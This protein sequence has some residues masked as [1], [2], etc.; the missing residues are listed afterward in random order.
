MWVRYLGFVILFGLPGALHA[1]PCGAPGLDGGYFVPEQ[2]TYSHEIEITYACDSGR[3]PAV[4]GWWA[5]STCQNGVWSP[6]PQCIG[7]EDCLPP[8]I[9]NAKF[10]KKQSGW[11]NP[12]NTIRVTCDNEYE[13][14]N[15]DATAVCLNGTWTSVPVCEIRNNTC[16]EPPQIPHAVIIGQKYQ[17]IFAAD[18]EVRYE[19][20]DGYSVEGAESQKNIF[21]ISGSWSE[22]PKCRR[23]TRQ[24]T[25]HGG[26]VEV[27]TSAGSGTQ[28]VGGGSGSSAGGTAGGHS[29]STESGTQPGGGG[30]GSGDVVRGGPT[31]TGSSTTSV[32]N[33][34]N[35]K[36]AFIPVN[37]CGVSPVIP[38]GVVVQTER[39]YLKYQ[40]NSYYTRVGPEIVVCTNDGRW[41]E[42]PFCQEAFCV[43]DLAQYS[44]IQIRQTGKEYIKEGETKKVYCSSYEYVIFTCTQGRLTYTQCKYIPSFYSLSQCFSFSF[45]SSAVYELLSQGS[46]LI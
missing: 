8:E 21:C 22:G 11:Y 10:N 1:Q 28:T 34:R 40:C 44:G 42:L 2:E 35:S 12:G 7:E 46:K 5:T 20:E 27:T 6:E 32:S 38:N 30:R 15:R 17:E 13:L 43:V 39:L 18:S 23:G 16:G 41:S 33:D 37:E 9:P 26:S 14:K 45:L 3:K 29:T 24:N 4:E 31:I 25:G 19:C 36:P